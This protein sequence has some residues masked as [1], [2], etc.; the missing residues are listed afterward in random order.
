MTPDEHDPAEAGAVAVEQDGPEADCTATVEERAVTLMT[1]GMT[2]RAVA[3]QLGITQKAAAL[4]RTGHGIPPVPRCNYKRQPHPKARDVR[5]LLAA[6]HSNTEVRRRTGT[7]LR[8]IARQREVTGVGP[9]TIVK[10]AT[11]V[12]PRYDEIRALLR[13][14]SNAQIVTKLGVDKDAVSRIRQETGI[15]WR[16]P[17][18]WMNITEKW[19]DHL[20]PLGDGHLEWTGPRASKSRTPVIRYGEASY[21]P[22]ALSFR[23]GN[24]GREP[25][26]HVYAECGHHQCLAPDHVND[27]PGRAAIRE[28]IRYILGGTARPVRCVHGHDQAEHGRYAP[29]GRAY[30]EACKRDYRRARSTAGTV[31]HPTDE[32]EAHR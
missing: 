31:Q 1:G 3:A 19:L 9:A 29:D 21:S 12:H 10:T 32:Q 16:R 24:P 26:G 15:V 5:S 28:Q 18:R 2:N 4:I 20:V 8:M 13:T 30:C 6:G 17:Q 11:R 23:W 7:D 25:V 27:E 22:A 14:H